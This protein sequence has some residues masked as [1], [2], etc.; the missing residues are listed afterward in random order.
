MH[1]VELNVGGT[2]RPRSSTCKRAHVVAI[3]P[4]PSVEPPRSIAYGHCVMSD[5]DGMD[6]AAL[7]E[8]LACMSVGVSVIDDQGRM[9]YFNPAA[10]KLVGIG[11]SDEPPD[12]WPRI[13]GLYKPDEVTPFPTAELPAVRALNGQVT[14]DVAMFV[15]NRVVS[16][17]HLCVSGRPWK[18][19]GAVVVFH[20]VAARRR[21][22]EELRKHRWFLESIVEE[23]PLMIFVKDARELRFERFN[24]AGETLL[25][26][27]REEMLGKNDYDFFP[28]EQADFFTT[29]DRETLELGKV[30]DIAEEPIRTASGTR[31]LHTRKVPILDERGH[32]NYLLGISEDITERKVAAEALRKANEL[33][34][35]RVS[36]RTAELEQANERLREAAHQKDQFL[37]ILSHEL[38]NPLA[39][40]LSGLYVLERM[41]ADSEHAQ[42]ARAV[43]GRQVSHLTRLVDDLLDVSRIAHG[44]V[45]LK[46]ERVD[47]DELAQRTAED[48]RSIFAKHDVEL[49]VQRPPSGVWV[50]GDATRLA[51]AIGN[52]LTNAAKFTPR[53][54]KATIT[55]RA[56]VERGDA[57][58]VVTD[59]GSGIT[60]EVMRGLFEPFAQADTTLD[61]SKG[62]LGL[63]LALVKGLVEMHGGSVS[64]VSAGLGSGATFAIRLPLDVAAVPARRRPQSERDSRHWRVLIIEDNIDAADTLKDA[65]ELVGHVVEVAHDGPRG[66][67]EA[68]T[69]APDVVL[70]DIGLPGMNGYEV[71]E[72]F[73]RDAELGRIALVALTGY[74]QP[75][76]VA[77]AMKAGFDAHLAK[78]P[79]MDA[80]AGTV[81]KAVCA[82]R[83]RSAAT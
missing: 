41:P 74:A 24:R 15:D 83:G 19:G 72:A 34:E 63:G 16:R 58:L 23:V 13:Y 71:A 3:A 67:A 44:K 81:D 80:L 25:G 49:E 26:I 42:R 68:K 61:R 39:P 73:R 65:L 37:A 20:D 35:Q 52:L 28:K 77:K 10:E 51:Q 5:D 29:R 21:D 12:A 40:I 36:D 78:P 69:F 22:E 50:N 76:D 59:T 4:R 62:G 11:P 45:Q 7:R 1:Y 33:L 56:D 64:V 31:W 54:G 53:G 48:L 17:R 30:V 79:T 32:A 46:R 43:I 14:D 57:V 75:E 66:I 47:L 60:P 55:V 18:R 82:R 27:K 6:E 8:V 38:R 2:A 70:C 9:L